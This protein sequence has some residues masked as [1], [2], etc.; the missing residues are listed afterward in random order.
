VALLLALITFVIVAIVFGIIWMIGGGTG[1]KNQEIVR[2]RM[3]SVRKAESRGEVSLDLKLVRDELYSNVPTLHKLLMRLPWSSGLQNFIN[4]AGLKMKAGKFVLWSA[5]AG[6]GA[7]VMFSVIYPNAPILALLFGLMAVSVPLI[8][9]SIKRMRRL[10]QFEERFPEALDLIGRAVRA[11]HAFTTGLE[12]VSKESAEPVS[13]EFRA[14]F[15]EQNFGLPLRDALL[16][17][18]ERVPLMDVRFFVTALLVQKE[19]GGN[20]AELLDELSRLIRERFRIYREVK[21][22][23]AQGRLTA[24]VLIALPFGLLLVLQFVNPDYVRVLWTDPIG[25]VLLGAA[26]GLQ[27]IGSLV[28]WKIVHIEV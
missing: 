24:A 15:E 11:G 8:V 14:T 26:A 21:V 23:T 10:S 27:V 25:P 3:E 4:Q 18:A 22:R 17:L 16:N 20:L 28:I 2:R 1:D 13:G 6:L 9:V 12:M 7:Y 5:V 19:T